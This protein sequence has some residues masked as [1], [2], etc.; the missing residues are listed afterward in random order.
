M[1]RCHC[2]GV[3][4]NIVWPQ[5]TAMVKCSR[6]ISRHRLMAILAVP[7][8]FGFRLVLRSTYRKY[9]SRSWTKHY[10][11]QNR[12]LQH[13]C[14]HCCRLLLSSQHE[15]LQTRLINTYNRR[16]LSLCT[17]HSNHCR[18]LQ[19]ARKRARCLLITQ[20]CWP[21][22]VHAVQKVKERRIRMLYVS[23]YCKKYSM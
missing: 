18:V 7:T 12:C 15:R 20:S 13:Q 3:Q 5:R 23:R 16:Y 11:A 19:A 1:G 22:P 4:F 21:T 14:R 8:I 9:T 17:M 6:K 2:R 10:Q